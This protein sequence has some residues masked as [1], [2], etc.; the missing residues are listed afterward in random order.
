M[1]GLILAAAQQHSTVNSSH[2]FWIGVLIG[3]VVG[4]LFPRW[5]AFLLAGA[6]VIGAG[7][8]HTD[9]HHNFSGTVPYLIVGAIALLAGLHFGRARGLR[10]LGEAD[11]QTRWRSVRGISRWI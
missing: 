5:I 2:I 8:F 6:A 10:H 3:V 9:S 1:G 7:L 11:F 4:A